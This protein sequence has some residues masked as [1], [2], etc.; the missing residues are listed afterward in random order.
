MELWNNYGDKT[1]RRSTS[2]WLCSLL[3]TPLSYA[4]RAQ[5]TVTLSSAEAELMAL[6]SGMAE[7]LHVQQLV[8]ELQTGMCTT[9]FSYSNNN[10]CLTLYTDSTSATSLASKLGV[11]R[12]S[13]HIALRY[14]WIQ[15]LPQAGEV[16]IK[17]ATTHEN[18]ADIY[19]KLLLAPVLQKHLPRNGLLALLDGE[20]EEECMYYLKNKKHNNKS[21][22]TVDNDN[23]VF[24]Q[25]HYNNM[26]KTVEQ[27][28][29]QSVE[30]QRQVEDLQLLVGERDAEVRDLAYKDLLPDQI[31]RAQHALQALQDHLTEQ[32]MRQLLG[33]EPLQAI[34][35]VINK[36]E[37]HNKHYYI[38]MIDSIDPVAVLQQEGQEK[39]EGDTRE[40]VSIQQRAEEILAAIRQR[41]QQ[42]RQQQ[43]RQVTTNDDNDDNG[44]A[45][46]NLSRR[47]AE[48][49]R[50]Q[51]EDT[52]AVTEMAITERQERGALQVR[53]RRR[54]RFVVA[55]ATT[56]LAC[57]STVTTSLSHLVFTT[58]PF[59]AQQLQV[60]SNY[61]S[62]R[63]VERLQLIYN[64]SC[65]AGDYYRRYYRTTLEFYHNMT[66]TPKLEEVINVEE[67]TAGTTIKEPTT[68]EITKGTSS[69]GL[70][71]SERLLGG[72]PC[73]EPPLQLRLQGSI[74][75]SWG[76]LQHVQ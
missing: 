41:K 46:V 10:K 57:L 45:E 38:K 53:K 30:L 50:R 36:K 20:G 56:V 6:S 2:G 39:E 29:K 8:E 73:Q 27:Y 33:T 70:E 66:T 54:R 64:Y 11:N 71:G 16:D 12:R 13:R 61:V 18:P 65:Q 37:E 32:H 23:K 19:T 59:V 9:T 40:G 44:R 24:R 28:K 60:A 72:Q 3:G 67:T 5:Q 51:E 31:L 35:G 52:T 15:G 7:S 34:L 55:T 74:P 26:H 22:S 63:Q 21:K 69:Q 58:L 75:Y 49:P 62:W 17:R 14:L 42:S 68:T 25:N 76:L 4:S 43:Q 48:T 1:T 47:R